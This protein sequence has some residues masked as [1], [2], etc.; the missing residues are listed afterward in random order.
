[1]Q[2][3][4]SASLS[5]AVSGLDPSDWQPTSEWTTVVFRRGLKMAFSLLVLPLGAS[6]ST[7]SSAYLTRRSASRFL[8]QGLRQIV[9]FRAQQMLSMMPNTFLQPFVCNWPPIYFIRTEVLLGGLRVPKS[10]ANSH[11]RPPTIVW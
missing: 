7:N 3:P 2:V 5:G 8:D 9:L 10:V 6:S 11:A 1:M 4:P